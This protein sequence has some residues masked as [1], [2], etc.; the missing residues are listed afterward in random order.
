[1]IASRCSTSSHRERSRKNTS[2]LKLKR[3]KI[4]GVEAV[5]LSDNS[6]VQVNNQNRSVTWPGRPDDDATFFRTVGC[7]YNFPEA[8]GLKLTQG[9]Y[10]NQNMS[11]TS[12]FFIVHTKGC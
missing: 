10:F 11:D 12:A 7:D 8:M 1:M 2:R 5:T 4:P 6:L 9:A 3:E